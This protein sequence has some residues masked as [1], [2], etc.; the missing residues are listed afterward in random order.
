MVEENHILTHQHKHPWPSTASITSAVYTSYFMIKN[1]FNHS[2][3]HKLSHK[4]SFT[5][6]IPSMSTKKLL[7]SKEPITNSFPVAYGF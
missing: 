4:Y 6:Y 2:V 1:I 5:F 3:N 7:Q